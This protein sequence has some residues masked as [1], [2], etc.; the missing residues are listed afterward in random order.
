MGHSFP[1]I[2]STLGSLFISSGDCTSSLIYGPLKPFLEA[3][4]RLSQKKVPLLHK[5]IPVIDI[6]TERLE[7]IS[8]NREYLA[9]V[10]TG[11]AKGLA[12][13]NKYYAKTDESIMYRCAMSTY[14]STSFISHILSAFLIQPD[15]ASSQI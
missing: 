13:L 10:R 1:I 7:D 15:S 9:S 5:V 2:Q 11:A 8:R 12:V 3:T 6:L 4:L 14:H